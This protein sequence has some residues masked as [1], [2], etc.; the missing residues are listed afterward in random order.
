MDANMRRE[1]SS[2]LR[3]DHMVMFL[4]SEGI[5]YLTEKARAHYEQRGPQ[6]NYSEA[7]SVSSS[8]SSE[9]RA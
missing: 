3:I 8:S 6:V 2:L 9:G 5:D 7:G 4:V 1:A